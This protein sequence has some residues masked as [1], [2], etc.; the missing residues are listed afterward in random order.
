MKPYDEILELIHS[1]YRA[2]ET[3]E[4]LRDNHTN[5][6]IPSALRR[7]KYEDKVVEIK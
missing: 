6:L 1:D 5:P 4:A 2:Q 7:G 3:G